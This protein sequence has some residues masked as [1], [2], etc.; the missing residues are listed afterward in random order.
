MKISVILLAL[1]I[2]L[3]FTANAMKLRLE[4][5][6]GNYSLTYSKVK[7]IFTNSDILGMKQSYNL[8][9]NRDLLSNC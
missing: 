2:I 8:H 6:C 5:L 3:F 4:G 9:Y 1:C 7:D